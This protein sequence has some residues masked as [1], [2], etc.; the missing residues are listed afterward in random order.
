MKT[1]DQLKPNYSPVYAAAMYPELAGIFH[2]HGYALAVHGSLARDF[3]LIAVPWADSVSEPKEVL[4]SV[5][6][7]FAVDL[8]GELTPKNHGRLCQTISVGFGHCA[9]DLSFMPWTATKAVQPMTDVTQSSTCSC[10]YKSPSV[11]VFRDKYDHLDDCPLKGS[12]QRV[13]VI[14][15]P[16]EGEL[17]ERVTTLEAENAALKARVY[18]LETPSREHAKIMSCQHEWVEGKYEDAV[19]SKCGYDSG[20]WYCETGPNHRCEYTGSEFCDHCGDPSERK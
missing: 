8:I 11:P 4:A 14:L 19:C 15:K 9:I 10:W 3:D 12:G 18:E 20:E 2:H 7:K 1:T 17:M 16:T 13:G 5:L 6:A